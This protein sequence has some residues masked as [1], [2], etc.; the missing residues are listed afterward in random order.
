MLITQ[1]QL[2]QTLP[3]Y[4]HTAEVIEYVNTQFTKYKINTPDR[5]AMFLAQTAVESVDWTITEEDLNYSAQRL[6]QVWPDHFTSSLAKDYAMKPIKLAN[7]IYA[8]RMGNG[9]EASGDGWKYRGRG[10]IQLTGKWNYEHFAQWCGLNLNRT[11]EFIDE[12]LTGEIAAGI[13]YWDTH[14]LN[15]YCDT[16]AT[17]IEK[18][19]N[20]ISGGHSDII[21]RHHKYTAILPFFT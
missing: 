18:I 11:I 9:D 3:R 21:R 8:N 7:Y 17:E 16:K 20:I 10:I 19:T 14:K 4:Q 12:Q 15:Y 2:E 13:Y 6:V 1:Q 5:I